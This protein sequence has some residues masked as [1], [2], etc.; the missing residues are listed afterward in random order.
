ML[1]KFFQLW[2]TVP[3]TSI[4]PHTQTHTNTHTQTHSH[5]HQHTHTHTHT[6]KIILDDLGEAVL[7]YSYRNLLMQVLYKVEVIFKEQTF[8]TNT[9]FSKY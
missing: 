9:I 5:T 1:F 7:F 3:K 8:P 6:H 2:N 4:T